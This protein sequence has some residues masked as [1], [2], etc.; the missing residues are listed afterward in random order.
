VD[1]L[2]VWQPWGAGPARPGG[3]QDSTQKAT[4]IRMS[5]GAMFNLTLVCLGMMFSGAS[6]FLA[7]PIYPS[8]ALARNVSVTETGIVLG[9]AF[10]ATFLF[11]PLSG[12]AISRFGVKNMFVIGNIICGLGNIGF[13]FLDFIETSSPYFW[14]SVGT[15]VF[16]AL[17]EAIVTPTAMALG[18]SQVADKNKGKTIVSA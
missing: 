7:V 12:I 6:Y 5:C 16:S 11:T 8:Q 18:L 15:R 3:T 9:S 17:G 1:P 14:L 10:L 4:Q 13:G 2:G